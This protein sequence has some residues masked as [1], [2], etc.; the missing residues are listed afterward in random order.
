MSWNRRPFGGMLVEDDGLLGDENAKVWA[1]PIR[2]Y[3]V[4]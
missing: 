2:N 4:V 3:I 1:H